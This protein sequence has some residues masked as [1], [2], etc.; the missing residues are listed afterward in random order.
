MK[1]PYSKMGKRPYKK[2]AYKRGYK[3]SLYR[4]VKQLKSRIGTAEV[5]FLDTALS[6]QPIVSGGTMTL[7]N[8]LGLGDAPNQREGISVT[9]KSVHV[10]INVSANATALTNV[11]RWIFFI[12]TQPN[13][14]VPSG[15]DLLLGPS[16][17]AMRNLSF[18]KRF[19]VL[20]DYRWTQVATSESGMK[21][22][23]FDFPIRG[24]NTRYAVGAATGTIADIATNSL[25]LYSIGDQAVNGAVWA[26]NIRLRYLDA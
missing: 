6:G 2:K 4:E 24:F 26:G 7:L 11:N 3:P 1:M 17:N 16:V 13:L 10:K 18:S 15:A 14:T 25:Y 20:K 8:G 12:D 23:Q 9:L 22:L 21:T 19:K 5:K